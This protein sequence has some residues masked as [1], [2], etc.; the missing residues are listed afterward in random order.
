MQNMETGT[1][2]NRSLNV[3]VPQDE[4]V[5]TYID[6]PCGCIPQMT[7]KKYP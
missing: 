3:R 1:A 4:F 6:E 2:K 5:S 7:Y